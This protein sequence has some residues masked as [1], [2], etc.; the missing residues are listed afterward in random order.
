MVAHI[1]GHEAR[2]LI[3]SA[4]NA[5]IYKNHI[6]ATKEQLKRK[7][8]PFPILK[9]VGEVKSIDDFKEENFVLEGYD[10]HPAI[11]TDLVIL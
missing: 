11:K 7:P 6:E 1:T 2:E 8:K 9:I 3:I 10:P 5:H 4:G